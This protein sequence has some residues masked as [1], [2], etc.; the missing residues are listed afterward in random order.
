MT[1][2]EILKE[3][4]E[5]IDKYMVYKKHLKDVGL[6]QM[7]AIATVA[8]AK[9]NTAGNYKKE[10]MTLWLDSFQEYPSFANMLTIKFK[11]AVDDEKKE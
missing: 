10:V 4:Q 9:I 11:D 5:I 6:T 7:L 3:N 2:V 1:K 8:F